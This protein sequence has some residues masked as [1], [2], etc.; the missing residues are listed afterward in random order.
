M[1]VKIEGLHCIVTKEPGDPVFRN[2]EWASAESTF[3]HHV[4]KEL[5]AKGHDVI[6][7]R[8]WKDGHLMG[9]EQQYIRTR[10]H[11]SPKPHLYIWNSTWAVHDA[12]M[13]F[14][15][16]GKTVLKVE[17]DVFLGDGVIP[18]HLFHNDISRQA[19]RQAN[20]ATI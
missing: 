4:K 9:D 6:K 19:M 16:H 15:E 11:R 18:W 10:S 14:N 7:K 12:G 8:M 17:F 5:I 3:L 20:Y 13:E 2:S 1:K